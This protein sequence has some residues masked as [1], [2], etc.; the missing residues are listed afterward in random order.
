M[1]YVSLVL[2]TFDKKADG[3]LLV[4]VEDTRSEVGLRLLL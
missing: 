3:D 4:E 2:D 1:Y